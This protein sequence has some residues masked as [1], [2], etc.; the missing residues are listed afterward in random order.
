MVHLGSRNF[1]YKICNYFNKVAKELNARWKS[2]VPASYG[3]RLPV[4]SEEG[5]SISLDS[6]PG[7]AKENRSQ[8]MEQV[9]EIFC[10]YF[11]SYGH[12]QDIKFDEPI[13][14]HHLRLL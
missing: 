11:S 9:Q 2:A 13:N 5:S 10:D 14:C 12:L 4:D 3:K 7:F 1:G 6:W 8:I